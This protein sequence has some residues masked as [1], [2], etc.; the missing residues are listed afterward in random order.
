ML[1]IKGASGSPPLGAT[2]VLGGNGG[3]EGEGE[4]GVKAHEAFLK[5]LFSSARGAGKMINGASEGQ[6]AKGEGEGLGL[7]LRLGLA[8]RIGGIEDVGMEVDEDAPEGK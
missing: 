2:G 3:K 5:T 4:G 1:S 8:A 7:G 6:E